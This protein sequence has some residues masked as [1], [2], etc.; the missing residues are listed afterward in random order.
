MNAGVYEQILA[1]PT[2]FMKE[3]KS[4]LENYHHVDKP[5]CDI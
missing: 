1:K 3:V 4:I 2:E 5:Q